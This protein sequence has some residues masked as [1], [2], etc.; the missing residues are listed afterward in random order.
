MK[1][2]DFSS[3]GELIGVVALLSEVHIFPHSES[4]NSA[5]DHPNLQAAKSRRHQLH[6][7]LSKSLWGRDKDV[8]L[9]P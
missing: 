9:L 6:A 1:A 4:A 3:Y 5:S 2:M 8:L 7:H